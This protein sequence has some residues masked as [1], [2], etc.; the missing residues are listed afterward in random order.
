MITKIHPKH[1]ISNPIVVP[2]HP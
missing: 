2:T 1:P